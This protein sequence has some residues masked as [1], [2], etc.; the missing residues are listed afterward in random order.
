LRILLPINPEHVENIFRGV[1]KFEFRKVRNRRPVDRIVIYATAPV[2]M[3][4]GEAEVKDTVDGTLSD[5]WAATAAYA[6]ISREF[7]D[8]YYEGR[9]SAFA[10]R[11][12]RVDAYKR[13]RHLAEVGVSNAPQSF[14]YLGAQEEGLAE[15]PH[16]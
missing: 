9:D 10:Y 3:I 15:A 8:S 4:V 14:V 1:K 13:P 6:G 12:G 2:S 11:L 7:F 5:V 16:I